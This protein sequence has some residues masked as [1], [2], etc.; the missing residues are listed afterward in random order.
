[1]IDFSTVSLSKMAIHFVGNK[2][3]EEGVFISDKIFTSFNEEVEESFLKYFIEPFR[4][5]AEFYNFYHPTEIDLN[6]IKSFSTALFNDTATF[7]EVAEKIAKS[8]YDKSEHPNINGGEL[9]VAW[10]AGCNFNGEPVD[11]IGIYKSELKDTFIKL[12]KAGGAYDYEL[13]AGVN[14]NEIDKGCIIFN[15]QQDFI[16]TVLDNINKSKEAKYW[17]DDFLKLIS[18]QD[19]FH[20]TKDYL[21]VARKYVTE[22]MPEVFDLS[23]ADK[24][25]YLNKSINYFKK[26]DHFAEEDF[27]QDVFQH[28]EVIDHFNQYKEKYANDNHVVLDND[29]D[30]SGQ[31]VKKQAK[32]FKSILK[33]DRN[34]HIYIH[35]NKDLIEKG[36]DT[37][38][39][40]YYKIYYEKEE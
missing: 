5:V 7:E 36:T 18:C 31:A 16:V 30:I 4:K 32:V 29:F 33:L 8:L 34:F 38:G 21:D 27:L 11:A 26:N 10:F 19:S 35:G 2:S 37:D 6:E 22:R 13:D 1:M 9:F 3:K 20:F 12:Q 28:S 25:D 17:M 15:T 23:K 39:R 24:I 14:I 40:K